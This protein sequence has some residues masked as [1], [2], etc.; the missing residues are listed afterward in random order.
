MPG[1][2]RLL[3]LI[4]KLD[5]NTDHI[6]IHTGHNIDSKLT[7][8]FLRILDSDILTIPSMLIIRPLVPSKEIP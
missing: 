3:R 4:P 5:D 8:V 2:I 6:F 7:E 1:I